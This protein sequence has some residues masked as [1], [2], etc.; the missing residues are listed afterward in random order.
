M[1]EERARIELASIWRADQALA[2]RQTLNAQR[3][4]QEVLL[5]VARGTCGESVGVSVIIQFSC[6]ISISSF[7]RK[8]KS[9]NRL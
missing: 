2:S 7:M 6:P 4:S 5:L 3:L 9:E 1:C 8:E